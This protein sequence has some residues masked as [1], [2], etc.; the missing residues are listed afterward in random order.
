MHISARREKELF[1][2]GRSV[3]R[4]N[5]RRQ[6]TAMSRLTIKKNIRTLKSERLFNDLPKEVVGTFINES[7]QTVKDKALSVGNSHVLAGHEG[8][9]PFL[10]ADSLPSLF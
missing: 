2:V 10:H 3:A 7:F 1:R 8:S 6:S 4:G 5:G 9:F